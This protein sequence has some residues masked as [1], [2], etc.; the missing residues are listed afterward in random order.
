MVYFRNIV[1]LSILLLAGLDVC[2][3]VRADFRYSGG[4]IE[5][6]SASISVAENRHRMLTNFIAHTIGQDVRISDYRDS[7]YGLN[8]SVSGHLSIDMVCF[9]T[10]DESLEDW[11]GGL[12]E[13]DYNKPDIPSEASER[14]L[15]FRSAD[16]LIIVWCNLFA[17]PNEIVRLTEEFLQSRKMSVR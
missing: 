6:D 5:V 15:F 17:D 2:A 4:V 14:C 8:D 12:A 3:Q 10:P 9:Q 16:T 7:F 13:N 11:L 1:M